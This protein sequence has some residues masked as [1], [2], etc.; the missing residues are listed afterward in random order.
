[1]AATNLK[2]IARWKQLWRDGR[3]HETQTDR[4][5]GIEMLF[6]LHVGARK[7]QCA[8]RGKVLGLQYS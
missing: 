1:V 5:Q 3:Y 2:M 8:L 6:P 7:S 4:Q